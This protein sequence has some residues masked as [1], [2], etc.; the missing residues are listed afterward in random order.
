MGTT[1]RFSREEVQRIL[2][3]TPKQLDYWERL[4]LAPV[5]EQGSSYDF[6]DLIGLRT[7]KQLIEKGVPA[8][9]LGRALD[10]LR[11]GLSH[12]EVPLTELRVLSDG[13]DVIVERGG[14]RLDPVSGQFVLN[15][16]T[17]E[18]QEKIRI[19]SRQEQTAEQWFARA[20]QCEQD[21]KNSADA[22]DAYG[23]ALRLQPQMVEALINCGTLFYEQGD[24]ERAADCFQRAAEVA[25]ENSLA[26]SNLGTVLQ[27]LGQ[28]QEARQH[29]RQ[30][31]Q[32][33]PANRDA[34]YNLALVCDKLGAQT[35][36]REHWQAYLKLDPAGP[37]GDYARQ[38]LASSPLTKFANR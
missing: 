10:A 15:F 19:I 16:E 21:T 12:A 13:R 5:K 33:D 7:V 20:L 27:E 28:T 24:F 31:V 26:H 36:A 1:D 30:A 17:R 6:R 8:H 29:L 25:P 32:L 4:R 35:E 11:E 2:E 3:L 23:Q 9:R 38:R 34:H 18:L 37:F 22:I 14:A